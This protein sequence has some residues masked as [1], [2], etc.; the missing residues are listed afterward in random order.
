MNALISSKKPRLKKPY[1][2]V[3]WPGMG[4]VAFKAVNYLVDE[5]KAVEFASIAPEEFF[6]FTGS[7]ITKGLLDLPALP[8]GKFYYWKNKTGK[9]DLVIFLSNAQ[10]DLSKADSYSKIIIF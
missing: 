10:P 3:A 7:V 9:N 6:Y 1:L 4:E 8:Q 5:L 2:V